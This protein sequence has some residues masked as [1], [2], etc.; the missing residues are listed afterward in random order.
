MTPLLPRSGDTH[1]TGCP[2]PPM[3]YVPSS[4]D[5]TRW[6]RVRLYRKAETQLRPAALT[7]PLSPP[8]R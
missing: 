2:A 3:Y 1:A 6:I 8:P 4:L 7:P 5:P